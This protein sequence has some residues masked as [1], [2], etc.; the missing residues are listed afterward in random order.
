MP[1]VSS[2]KGGRVGSYYLLIESPRARR[3]IQDFP[4]IGGTREGPGR[5]F[6]GQN[7]EDPWGKSDAFVRWHGYEDGVVGRANRLV[8]Q[9]P[10]YTSRVRR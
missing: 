9:A 4:F 2:A 7:S 1:I 8:W 10:R 5:F 6:R 3:Y